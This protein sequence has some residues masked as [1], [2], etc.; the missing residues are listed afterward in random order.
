MSTVSAG[1]PPVATFTGP[2][3]VPR[4]PRAG[5]AGE[6]S[7][8]HR[9]G[10]EGAGCAAWVRQAASGEPWSRFWTRPFQH[11]GSIA[12]V[13]RASAEADSCY[14][15]GVFAVLEERIANR[16]VLPP[17]DRPGGR[18]GDALGGGDP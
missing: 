3:R 8:C 12:F 1:A 7:T 18:T 2:L 4:G 6:P 14:R 13:A 15:S 17:M 11:G 16:L 5:G 9:R 10:L